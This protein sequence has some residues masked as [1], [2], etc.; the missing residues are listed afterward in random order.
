MKKERIW[1]IVLCLTLLLC[2]TSC[3]EGRAGGETSGGLFSSKPTLQKNA[4]GFYEIHTAAELAAYRDVLEDEMRESYSPSTFAAARSSAVLMDDIDM[5]SLCGE[6]VGSWRPI[7]FHAVELEQMDLSGNTFAQGNFFGTFRG[8]GHTIS[9]LYFNDEESGGGLFYTLREAEISDLTFSNCRLTGAFSAAGLGVIAA[10]MADGSIRNVTVEE[11]V[12]ICGGFRV[13]GLIGNA[14]EYNDNVIIENCTNR[15][16]IMGDRFVG[17]IVGYCDE[18]VRIIQCCNYGKVSGASNVGG[19][20]GFAEGDSYYHGAITGC[21]NYGSVSGI[22]GT[23]HEASAQSPQFSGT[24]G[25]IVGHNGSTVSF[26]VNAGTVDG[27][28]YDGYDI[29][30]NGGAMSSCLN[31]GTVTGKSAIY[32]TNDP[33]IRYSANIAAGDPSLTDGSLVNTLNDMIG[34]EGWIQGTE[35]P[36]WSGQK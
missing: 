35:F 17:G 15:A 22:E 19:I 12:S 13:G 4:D 14:L 36:V 8:N 24:I 6:D 32:V 34:R 7:G 11:N 30:W 5:S 29:G 16:E 25:G 20:L 28:L 23:G 27:G 10:G 2:L 18:D 1:G 33:R 9:N 31:V 3:G 26:C 21:I